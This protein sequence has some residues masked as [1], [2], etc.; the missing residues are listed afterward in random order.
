MKKESLPILDLD[1]IERAVITL[2]KAI[3]A[4]SKDVKND[5]VRDACIQ[6]FEYSYELCT[7]I[8]RRYLVLTEANSGEIAAM[9]FPNLIRTGSMR[10]LLLHDW[11]RWSK[12]RDA[13]NITS[14][15]YD[16]KKAK[17]VIKIIPKFIEEANFL[18]E[19]LNSLVKKS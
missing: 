19:K 11:E 1:A 18:L 8:L 2:E 15:T 12:Y 13:R 7:K 17:K 9:S 10:N 6:R 3:Q 14:H 16:E 5:L 4:F